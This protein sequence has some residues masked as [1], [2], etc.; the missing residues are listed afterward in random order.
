M[1]SVLSH[2]SFRTAHA[3]SLSVHRSYNAAHT[4]ARARTHTLCMQGAVAGE[5]GVDVVAVR[6]GERRR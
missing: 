4:H 2:F 5:A 1:A 3:L 6:C